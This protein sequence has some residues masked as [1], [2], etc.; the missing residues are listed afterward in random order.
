[1]LSSFGKYQLTLFLRKKI[2]KILFEMLA[3]FYYTFAISG[4]F[5]TLLK[6]CLLKVPYSPDT[7]I[8]SF[9]N[10][11]LDIGNFFFI[12]LLSLLYTQ[13]KIAQQNH[14]QTMYNN[15]SGRFLADNHFFLLYQLFILQRQLFATKLFKSLN[16]TSSSTRLKVREIE[17]IVIF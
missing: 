10:P 15:H 1:M 5:K 17:G 2:Y 8:K 16:T 14:L 4:E 9:N 7:Y 6:Q 3:I 12:Y 13:R 11:L